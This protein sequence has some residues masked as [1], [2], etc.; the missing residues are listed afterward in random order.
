MCGNGQRRIKRGWVGGEANEEKLF[1]QKRDPGEKNFLT[2]FGG[3]RDLGRSR[4]AEFRRNR[5]GKDR[6]SET[7]F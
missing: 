6:G 5:H 7:G 1:R 3:S 4:L 2:P